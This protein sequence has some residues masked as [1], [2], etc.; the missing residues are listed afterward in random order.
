MNYMLKLI[1]LYY[2]ILSNISPKTAANSAFET[3][4]KVRKKDIREREKGYFSSAQN[5]FLSSEL[6][7]H[8]R[9]QLYHP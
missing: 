2:T 5:G 1:K 8:P 4:Q 3:F 9:G 7:K 6:Q